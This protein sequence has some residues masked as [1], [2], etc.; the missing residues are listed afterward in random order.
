[1][2]IKQPSTLKASV[3][4]QVW[5]RSESYHSSI[6]SLDHVI[7]GHYS[8]HDQQNLPRLPILLP[9]TN[10]NNCMDRCECVD[11]FYQRATGQSA[12]LHSIYTVSTG[13]Q[14]GVGVWWV[15]HATLRY[16]EAGLALIT[17]HAVNPH[18]D[19]CTR[20]AVEC[21]R[22]PATITRIAIIQICHTHVS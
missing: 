15:H 21:A 16:F 14:G 18:A 2:H 9:S 4:S 5:A 10:H 1:M 8:I 17:L 19:I 13:L 7:T 20:P 22:W 11:N 12:L 3:L 6:V